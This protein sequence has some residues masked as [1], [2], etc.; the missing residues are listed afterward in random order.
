MRDVQQRKADVLA[1]L[2]A[3]QDLW[4]ASADASGRPHL[5]AVSAWWDGAEIV[6]ATTAASRTAR[7]LSANPVVRLALGLPSDAVV[8]DARVVEARPAEEAE[9]LARGF[10]AAVGW[11]P[12]EVGPGWSFYRLKPVRIQAYRGY[13]ELAGRDVMLRSEWL[14]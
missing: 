11:N 14:T 12:R 2:G 4:L 9:V 3:Q 6:I 5:I 1:A 8:V 10:A 13:D 7:N